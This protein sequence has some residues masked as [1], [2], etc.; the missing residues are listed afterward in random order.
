MLAKMFVSVKPKIYITYQKHQN[1]STAT[2]WSTKDPALLSSYM[3]FNPHYLLQIDPFSNSPSVNSHC[4][5]VPF[6]FS[7]LFLPFIFLSFLSS[8]LVHKS[9]FFKQKRMKMIYFNTTLWSYSCAW[10]EYLSDQKLLILSITS[11]H[12]WLKSNVLL[13]LKIDLFERCSLYRGCF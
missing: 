1:T 7:F 9:K 12:I 6:P 4:Y 13:K 5:L 8:C 10:E 3:N 11:G 2:S